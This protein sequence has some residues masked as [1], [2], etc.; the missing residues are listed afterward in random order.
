MK[1]KLQVGKDLP[2]NIAKVLAKI[3]LEREKAE[4]AKDGD[5]IF[6]FGGEDV[7]FGIQE[8]YRKV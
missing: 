5:S 2:K 8:K 7:R 1:K 3:S 4:L 6:L